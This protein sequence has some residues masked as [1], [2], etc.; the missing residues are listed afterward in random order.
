ACDLPSDHLHEPLLP[1]LEAGV[2]AVAA[3]LRR[4]VGASSFK[5]GLDEMGA[6]MRFGLSRDLPPATLAD[7]RPRTAPPPTL[8]PPDEGE[9]IRRAQPLN[10]L[11]MVD[12]QAAL[13]PG[14]R[15]CDL[16]A[17]FLRRV[18]ELG[19]T[20]NYVNP[21]WQVVPARVAD[22]PFTLTGEVAFPLV[23]TDRV[24]AEGD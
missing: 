6:A 23:S 12:V 10:E 2:T 18:F 13:V 8:K 14:I 15:Q 5:L 22:G 24:L 19:A 4:L 20:A 11:A 16:S 17:L 1:E 3:R 9:C 21:I 7:A